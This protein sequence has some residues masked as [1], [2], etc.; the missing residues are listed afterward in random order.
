[1]PLHRDE[2]GAFRIS[3]RGLVQGVGFRPFVY[4]LAVSRGLTGWVE[5]RSDGVMVCINANEGTTRDFCHALEQEAPRAASI[6][7]IQT[8]T[9]PAFPAEDFHIR[10]S[11]HVEGVVTEVSPDIAVCADCLRDMKAQEHRINYPFINCTHCGPR[12]TI[13]RAIPYDRAQ[14]SMDVFPMCPRCRK[15]YEDILDRRF[16]AQPVACR[17]CGPHYTLHQ[18]EE[19]TGD[20]EVILNALALGLGSGEIF[21]LKG[22]GGYHLACDAGDQEAVEKLRQIKNRDGKPFAVMFPSLE[23][24]AEYCHINDAEKEL[25]SSWQRPIVILQKK[26]EL[27]PAVSNGLYGIGAMLPYMPLH[28]L[29]FE[30]L[31]LPAIVLTSANLSDEPILTEDKEAMERLGKQTDGILTYNRRIVNRADDSV[32]MVVNG[33][34]QLLRR[35]RSWVPAPVRS[36]LEM[37]GIFAAGAELVNSF[38]I[39]KGKQVIPSQYIGDLKNAE[40]LA[41]YR[42]SYERFCNLF[43]FKP[44]IIVRDLHPDYLSSRFAEELGLEKGIPVQALQHHHAHIASVMLEYGIADRQVIGIS[45]DGTGLGTD[46][47]IWGG[48]ML[49]GGMTDLQR[50]GHLRA[51]A[52]PGGDAAAHNPW[53]MGVSYLADSFGNDPGI[54][55]HFFPGIQEKD[56]ALIMQMIEKNVNCPLTSSTGRLFDAVA[57]ICGLCMRNSFHAEA[58]MRLEAAA[59]MKVPGSYPY[60]INEGIID[61]RLMIT[62]IAEEQGQGI[63]PEAISARFHRTLARALAESCAEIATGKGIRNVVFSGGSFQNRI[64]CT[65][66]EESLKREGFR[67][68]IPRELPVNDQGIAAGQMAIAAMMRMNGMI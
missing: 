38:A 64:L 8:E 62:A 40:T 46:G 51:V 54:L 45:L 37:E 1:M 14:T 41:F 22:L 59:N 47:T 66:L 42:E 60:E 43:E 39:G 6:E 26:K 44:G 21:A 50:A 68:F 52:M 17:H 2:N 24:A 35:S 30:K 16:H 27:A 31:A 20:I 32:A 28:Y 5:N 13:I 61:L 19:V 63:G 34:P 53:R 18:G 57:A 36:S 10:N 12:F 33:V 23:K 56:I 55:N 25:L 67:V 7:Q 11:K 65:L 49:V 3:V 9:I 58:P 48:E 4:R 15:E 29:L